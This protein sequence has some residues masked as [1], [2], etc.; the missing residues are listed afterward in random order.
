M[1]RAVRTGT[2]ADAAVVAVCAVV[3]LL[4]TIL[5][6]PAREQIASAL[7]GTVL[8]PLIAL[9]EEAVRARN[10]F[11]ER[12]TV[13]ARIDSLSL[14]ATKLADYERE[15]IEL[16]RILGLSSQLAWGFVP[17]EAV[18]SAGRNEADVV[19]LTAG[20]AAGVQPRSAVVSPDGLVGMVTT[21]D[22][23]MSMAILWNNNDFRVS[24]MA[25]DGTAFGIVQPHQGTGADSYLLELRGVA[26]RDALRPGTLITSSGLGGVFPRGIP[27]GT[28]LQEIRTL[29]GWARAYL[30]RPAVK[31]QDVTT[32]MILKPERAAAGVASVWASANAADS[33][34]RRV[35]AAGDSLQRREAEL[36][37]ARQRTLD[38]AAALLNGVNV[39]PS[40]T[41]SDSVRPRLNLPG[42]KRDTIRRDVPRRP[43]S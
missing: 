26:F 35:A 15:N 42:I 2:R 19:M 10:A 43:P 20:S 37:A 1:A 4:T 29:E 8:A 9:Q 33:A 12:E 34:M 16:R 28:V 32:V 18:H 7:R 22:A 3:S 6:G 41:A 24:A 13:N 39:A 5:P 14:R 17:A 30:L 25:V 21:V 23:N 27:V 36:R 38:S 11:L 40:V 31:P